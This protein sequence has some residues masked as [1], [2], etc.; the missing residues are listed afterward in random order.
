VPALRIGHDQDRGDILLHQP[1][2]NRQPR[3][4]AGENDHRVRTRRKLILGIE[5][6]EWD[7][8][9]GEE[10]EHADDG[11]E[12]EKQATGHLPDAR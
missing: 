3:V 12:S 4:G 10:A 2:R 7:P 11:Q 8:G 1:K 5:D 9:Q 6:E